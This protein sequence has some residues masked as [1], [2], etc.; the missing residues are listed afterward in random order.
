MGHSS[1]S[2]PVCLRGA[3]A[4][5]LPGGFGLGG[6]ALPLSSLGSQK[7]SP[8]AN[9]DLLPGEG[10]RQGLLLAHPPTPGW[11]PPLAGSPFTLQGPN[12]ST[13][14]GEETRCRGLGLGP[15]PGTSTQWA[16]TL[17]RLLCPFL[18]EGWQSKVHS[19]HGA[20]PRQVPS[21]SCRPT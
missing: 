5:E 16:S 21:P 19:K 12:R 6:V 18:S 11:A 1:C 9:G 10:P 20:N 15:R 8:R 4:K 2:F 3:W 14:R 13:R 17:P 7:A